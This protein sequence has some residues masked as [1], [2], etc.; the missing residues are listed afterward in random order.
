[1]KLRHD[2]VL[3]HDKTENGSA[4]LTPPAGGPVL[5]ATAVAPT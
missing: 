5:L 2:S 4:V 1:M 3:L